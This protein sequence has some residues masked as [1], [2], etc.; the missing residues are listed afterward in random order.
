MW[1]RLGT[2]LGIGVC[3]CLVG[4]GGKQDQAADSSGAANSPPLTEKPQESP[5]PAELKDTEPAKQAAAGPR[6]LRPPPRDDRLDLARLQQAGATMAHDERGNVTGV[7]FSATSTLP[8][9][10]LEGI[11][12]LK[13]LTVLSGELTDGRLGDLARMSRIAR[14]LEVLVLAGTPITDDALVHLSRFPRL[15]RLDLSNTNLHDHGMGHLQNLSQLESLDL[16]WTKIKGRT[17]DKLTGLSKLSSLNL[18]YTNVG[19]AELAPLKQIAALKVINVEFSAVLDTDADQLVQ[20][21]P[22]IVLRGV[23]ATEI[24]PQKSAEADAETADAAEPYPPLGQPA[25]EIEGEDIDGKPLKLSDFRGKVVLLDFWGHWCPHCRDL[26][27]D[28]RKLTKRLGDKPFLVVGINSDQ[29]RDLVKEVIKKEKLSWNSWWDG[30]PTGRIS[31][32]WKIN[33]WPSLFLVDH[34]GKLR[35]RDL[36]GSELERAIDQL[37][38]EIP[39]PEQEP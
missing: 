1:Y 3:V 38:G 34:E 26:Y 35:H 5:P 15:K 17:L 27:P 4:C 16:S 14:Q 24:E 22:G 25:P 18:S 19:A 39:P 23:A 37:L 7:V 8:I 13:E 6:P 12:H 32:Q 33:R 30:G 11:V 36:R 9:E 21:F 2:V 20:D 31:K 10:A 28:L 29:N